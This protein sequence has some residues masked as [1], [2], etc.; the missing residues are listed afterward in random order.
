MTNLQ[1]DLEKIL[2][3]ARAQPQ[4]NTSTPSTTQIPNIS[5]NLGAN[6]G[7][8]QPTQTLSN[9]VQKPQGGTTL[10][11]LIKWGVICV[12]LV[13]VVTVIVV[14]I[15]RFVFTKKQVLPDSKKKWQNL[16]RETSTKSKTDADAGSESVTPTKKTEPLSKPEQPL[17]APKTTTIN[18]STERQLPTKTQVQ[19]QVQK[20]VTK[21]KNTDP[22]F[23]PL[24]ELVI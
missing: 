23:T 8:I 11:S 14:V 19:V 20:Q 10:K 13:I 21:K 5:A 16:S 24:E 3:Q 15:R 18:T 7:G 6:A 2:Q 9:T 4:L 1:A 17:H 22:E 12:V